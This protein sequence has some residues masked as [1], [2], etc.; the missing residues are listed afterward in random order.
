MCVYALMVQVTTYK[1]ATQALEMA[2]DDDDDADSSVDHISSLNP[3]DASRNSYPSRPPRKQMMETWLLLEF[4]NRWAA[5]VEHKAA[6]VAST[7]WGCKSHL[8]MSA[9]TTAAL[10]TRRE[11]PP[12]L[13]ERAFTRRNPT[14]GKPLIDRILVVPAVSRQNNNSRPAGEQDE[15]WGV[16]Q[17]SQPRGTS[18]H[19]AHQNWTGKP[20]SSARRTC[21]L[22]K[23]APFAPHDLAQIMVNLLVKRQM[24]H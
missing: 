13:Q 15:M 24:E 11:R 12:Q 22:Y 21:I 23:V 4:C 19:G 10:P 5:T 2:S 9:M 8:D 18:R 20:R 3:T 1:H 16:K 7:I 6:N 14:S 17:H